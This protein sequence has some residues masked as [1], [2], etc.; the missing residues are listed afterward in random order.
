MWC[1]WYV[2]IR[3]K[4]RVLLYINTCKFASYNTCSTS[5]IFYCHNYFLRKIDDTNTSIYSIRNN[6]LILPHWLSVLMIFYTWITS[7][8]TKRY[9][10]IVYYYGYWYVPVAGSSKKLVAYSGK[11]G[12][13]R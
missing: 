9:I 2:V 6:L 8:I 4:G 3:H 1:L 12:D 5:L 11:P 10:S 13:R 7:A